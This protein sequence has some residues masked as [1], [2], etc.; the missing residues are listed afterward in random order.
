M[1]PYDYNCFLFIRYKKPD[2]RIYIAEEKKLTDSQITEFVDIMKPV[3]FTSMFGKLGSCE[4]SEALRN[5]AFLRPE[6][7]VPQH[8]EK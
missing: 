8:L 2:W 7:I 6:R 5:L 1:K 4:M 3:V